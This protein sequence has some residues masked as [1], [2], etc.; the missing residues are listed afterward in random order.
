MSATKK[1]A[2]ALL[3]LCNAG[4][5]AAQQQ[6]VDT[7]PVTGNENAATD[8]PTIPVAAPNDGAAESADLNTRQN[9]DTQHL[10]EVVV[11]ATKRAASL[12]E[13]P[14]SITSLD[15]GDLERR[16]VQ[17]IDDIARLTPGVN[18]ATENGISRVTIRG[19]AANNNTNATTGTLFGNASF[20]DSYLPVA[21][22]DPQPFDLKSVEVLKGPQGT[23]FGASALNGAIRYV[24]EAP[25]FGEYSAKYFAQ[26]TSINEG[27]SDP[28]YGAAV[29]L[30]AGDTVALR[31]AGF[32]RRS[33]G[34]VDNLRLDEPNSNHLSQWGIRGILAWQPDDLWKASLTLASQNTSVNDN[35]L[36]DNL[37]QQLTS[38]NRP[39]NSWRETYYRL[40]DLDVERSFDWAQLVSETA[41]IHKNTQ[42]FLE[43]TRNILASGAI[44]LLGIIGGGDSN[45]YSQ[46][47]RLVSP[48]DSDSRWRWIT[49]VFASRQDIL[50]K[51]DIA[52]GNGIVPSAIDLSSLNLLLPG[53]GDL[54]N[55]QGNVSVLGLDADIRVTEIAAFADVTRKLG[56]AWELTLGGRLY[57]TRSFGSNTQTGVLATAINGNPA[58]VKTGGVE[59]RNFNPKASLLWHTT[60][61]I[62]SYATISK[63]FRVGGLQP[64][65]TLPTSTTQAP[66][67]F[68]SDT[69]W[70]YEGGVRTTWLDRSLYIDATAFYIDW[71]NPQ[72]LQYD[73][74]LDVNYLDNVGGVKSEGVDLMAQWITPFKLLIT[75]S[76]TWTETVTTA[77]FETGSGNVAPA[78]TPW[79]FS[80]KWQTAT[81]LSY[82]LDIASWRLT[83]AITH[84]YLGKTINDLSYQK[85]IFN[86]QQLDA[87]LGLQN[88]NVEWMPEIN[89]T[90]SNVLDKRGLTSD[91]KQGQV[92]DATYS[93]PRTVIVRVSGSF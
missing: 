62:V 45:T 4:V 28:A 57:Q 40:A 29:N 8:L 31:L 13:I 27:G 6:P 41:F 21:S 67:T 66:A 72:T 65:E 43:N 18:V 19:I 63:G 55:S 93:Q 88:R 16:G 91:I 83:P 78:G 82:P 86:F 49:G 10:E 7:Q 75:T 79:P 71:R 44:P 15:G 70:N 68:K 24:P 25:V 46:E 35:G 90:V 52:A 9:D 47:I 81:T 92:T 53:L 58:D 34:Y 51:A 73:S 74:T 64:G 50:D 26:Y 85:P 2:V 1:R 89:M 76:A 22:L 77:S 32:D 42:S 37:D 14:E 33:P 36:V 54:V 3:L 38:D 39:R 20:T 87:M 17:G 12:R 80:P 5:S 60:D 84:T 11:T 56:D 61:N 23:L 59:E 48:N 69:I 30:P